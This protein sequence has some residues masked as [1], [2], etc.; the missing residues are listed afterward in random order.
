[1]VAPSL[2]RAGMEMVVA[3]LVRGLARRGHDIGVTC[4]EMR[5]SVG[6]VLE[7]EGIRVSVVPAPGLRTLIVPRQLSRWLR[8]RRPDVVHIHSGIWS[9]AAWAARIARVPR[10]VFTMHGLDGARPLYE[11]MIDAWGARYT[12]DAVAVSEAFVPYLIDKARVPRSRIRVIPNGIDTG[13]FRPG[14]RTGRVRGALGFP[15]AA[16]VLGHVARFS[17]VKNHELLVAAFERVASAHPA[18]HLAF[19]GDGPLRPAIEARVDALGLRDRV[20][21]LG[22]VGDLHEVYRD[23]D[24]LVLSSQTEAAPMSVLEG[25]ASGLAIVATAV[26]GLPA[27]LAHGEAGILVPPADAAAFATALSAVLAD[28]A[29]RARL[30]RAA[31]ERAEQRYDQEHMLDAYEAVYAGSIEVEPAA[32]QPRSQVGGR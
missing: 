16:L 15:D 7:R 3:G 29:E 2:Q 21:F 12:T 28:P 1:M 31:R 25:M 24:I 26:G 14:P 17:P 4:S 32:H 8:Q 10:V 19:I 20:G 5:G 18:A 30:S 11:P 13:L 9:K 23:L 27:I 6:E 22:E